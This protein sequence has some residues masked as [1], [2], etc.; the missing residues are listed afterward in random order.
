MTKEF[1]SVEEFAPQLGTYPDALC[2]HTA[3]IHCEVLAMVS[4]LTRQGLLGT[5]D[6]F[7]KET[8]R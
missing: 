2:A 3:P 5:G 1:R 6:Q 7:E 8:E 4:L